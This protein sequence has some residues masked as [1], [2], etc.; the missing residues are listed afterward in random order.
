MN[1]WIARLIAPRQAPAA[2]PARA[3]PA[4]EG[5][6]LAR[7]APVA[8]SEPPAAPAE[9]PDQAHLDLAFLAWMANSPALEFAPAGPR[10]REVVQQL[11][12]L[13]GD[14]ASHARILPRT[15][16]VIPPL[17]AKLRSPALALPELSQQVSRDVTRVA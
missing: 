7:P 3:R 8:A 12:R 9:Q 17:L 1:A 13:I 11:D 4:P 15:A 16:A 10:E 2:A 14:K 5:V 6:A